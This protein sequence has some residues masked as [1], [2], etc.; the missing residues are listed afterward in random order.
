MKYRQKIVL[1]S[2]A[3]LFVRQTAQ[4]YN[5]LRVSKTLVWGVERVTSVESL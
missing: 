5:F 1:L 4:Q 3:R 2:G